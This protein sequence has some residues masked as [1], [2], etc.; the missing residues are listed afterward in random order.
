MG[1]REARWVRIADAAQWDAW[2]RALPMPHVLQSW[3]WGAFKAR[4]G[5]EAERWAWMAEGEPRAWVQ[6]LRRAI[7]RLPLCVLYAP[8][9]PLALD[10]E[11]YEAALAWLEARAQ[12]LRAVW[13]KADGDPAAPTLTLAQQRAVL[14]RRGW[15]FS[16]QQVQFRNTAITDLR[17]DD[18]ALLA[19]MKPKWR[20]NIRLAERR[21]VRVRTVHPVT[22]AD[23]A[24]LNALY[25]ETARRDGFVIREPRY[26]ADVWRAMDATALIAE[27]AEEAL[28]AA[29]LFVFGARAWYFY[30]MSRSEGREHMPNYLLQWYALRWAR[31]RGCSFYDWWG[32]PEREDD[33]DHPLSG[34]WR[35]K[36]GFG[37]QFVEGV[38]AWDYAPS[39]LL[40]AL[41]LLWQRR[42]RAAL[43]A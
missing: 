4:W 7:G 26:Y 21:G 28:A 11:A 12:Q 20:Y 43:A 41:Y 3:A 10:D 42:R 39:R 36:R 9:G 5:W 14:M 32:A 8:K 30:G 34:V 40:Y 37:A 17:K 6:L 25:A 27:R 23:A 22:D 2:L 24:L 1:A 15:R 18:A 29:V 38:G 19:E 35:F 13:V 33:P 31:D 16:P